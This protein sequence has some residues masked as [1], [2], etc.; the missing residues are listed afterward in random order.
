[1]FDASAPGSETE[2]PL[3]MAISSPLQFA[4]EHVGLSRERYTCSLGYCAEFQYTHAR[5]LEL[6][7]GRAAVESKRENK[8][9]STAAHSIGRP[10]LM[11][12]QDPRT[13]T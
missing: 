9:D 1:M 7:I 10:R 12:I 4:R 5:R 11:R 3:A 13:P 8:L 6:Y 2:G